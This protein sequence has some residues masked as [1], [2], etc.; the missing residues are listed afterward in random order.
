VARLALQP[1]QSTYSFQWDTAVGPLNQ[2]NTIPPRPA[3]FANS[4]YTSYRGSPTSQD[5]CG[6][7]GPCGTC[8][9][10]CGGEV[11][12]GGSDDYQGA[13]GGCAL[14]EVRV[15]AGKNYTLL[16]TPYYYDYEKLRSYD[17]YS[18]S[19]KFFFLLASKVAGGRGF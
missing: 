19:R 8:G 1:D 9:S 4:Y 3:P 5:N 14:V 12:P 10:T 16:V 17:R 18:G 6:S 15:E 13:Y 2:S 7:L 11:V